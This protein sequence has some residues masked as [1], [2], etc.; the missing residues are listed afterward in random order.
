MSVATQRSPAFWCIGR[1]AHAATA[2]RS[3][4]EEW[5]VSSGASARAWAL[6]LGQGRTADGSEAR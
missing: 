1:A 6:V 2:L 4:S 3:L 5:S